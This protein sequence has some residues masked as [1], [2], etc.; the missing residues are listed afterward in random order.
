[1]EQKRVSF[2]IAKAIKN[3]GYPQVGYYWYSPQ[4]EE[5]YSESDL[6]EVGYISSPTYLDVWL[7]L[8]REK[9]VEL[10][11]IYGPRF[12]DIDETLFCFPLEYHAKSHPNMKH[13]IQEMNYASSYCSS[14]GHRHGN[15]E[16]A[17]PEEA[18]VSAIEYLVANNLIK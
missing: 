8:W 7:W 12:N 15:H 18:V 13:I 11:F 9:K 1:M 5:C 3:A 4:G 17:D 6:D 16:H 14:H 2:S 10:S